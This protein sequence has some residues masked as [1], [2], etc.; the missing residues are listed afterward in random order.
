MIDTSAITDLERG[1]DA[2]ANASSSLSAFASPSAAD[3][4]S[5][6]KAA[7][8]ELLARSAYMLGFDDDYVRAMSLIDQRICSALTA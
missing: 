3:G 2:Y 4:T 5:K 7:D 8:L 6:L 1:R